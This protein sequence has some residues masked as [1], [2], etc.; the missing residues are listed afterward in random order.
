MN[1]VIVEDSELILAQLLRIFSSHSRIN[2]QGT[3]STEEQAV[4]IILASRPDAVLLDLSLS[5]GSGMRVLER[6]RQ[7]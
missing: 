3:A 1:I 4:E 6:I 5:P 7:A 2:I